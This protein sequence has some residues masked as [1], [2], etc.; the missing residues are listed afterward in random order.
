MALFESRYKAAA[1]TEIERD[2][3]RLEEKDKRAQSFQ[4]YLKDH[5]V[6]VSNI[7]FAE[8]IDLI[9]SEQ[10]ASF[11]ARAAAAKFELFERTESRIVV[12]DF[13]NPLERALRFQGMDECAAKIESERSASLYHAHPG[14]AEATKQFAEERVR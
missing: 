4:D 14:H 2:L 3:R 8:R 9:S 7:G 11:R 12:N 5:T 13:E 1:A 6:T 10:A